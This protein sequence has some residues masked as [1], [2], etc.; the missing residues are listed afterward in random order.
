MRTKLPVFAVAATLAI[1]ACTGFAEE[2]LA[3]HHLIVTSCCSVFTVKADMPVNST[4]SV[5]VR[6]VYGSDLIQFL[7]L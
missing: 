6:R 2:S 5:T 3:K 1:I 4:N 7:Q